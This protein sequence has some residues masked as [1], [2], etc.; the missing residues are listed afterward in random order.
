MSHQFKSR[1]LALIVGARRYVEN[2]GKTCELVE[3]LQPSE[4][5]KWIDP[6]D[7]RAVENAAGAQCWLVIGDG[8]FGGW[9]NTRGAC[10]VL[11]SHL[12][13]LRGD[14]A[15]EQQKSQEVPA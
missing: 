14:F 4:V 7:G 5:S 15:T 9:K 10:L 3:L 11:P 13:P 12:M 8:L 2:I 1:D 6:Q